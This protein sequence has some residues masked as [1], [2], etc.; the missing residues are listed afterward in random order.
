M[1]AAEFSAD[2]KFLYNTR[3][4]VTAAALAESLAAIDALAAKAPAVLKTI[5]P[6]IG[7]IDAQL[8]VTHI[9]IGSYDEHFLFRLVFGKGKVAERKLE[10]LRKKLKLDKMNPTQLAAL[11]LSG[12]IIYGV[13]QFSQS[14]KSASIH[15]ENSFNSIGG[16]LNMSGEEIAA[17]LD[18][19]IRNKEDLRRQTVKLIRP[20]GLSET[21]E[22][23]IAG[24]DIQLTLPPKALDVVPVSYSKAEPNEPEEL[25]VKVPAVIRALDLDRPGQGW[26]GILPEISERRLPVELAEGVNPLSITPGKITYLDVNLIHSVDHHGNKSPKRIVVER[27]YDAKD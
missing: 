25:L 6:R 10:A 17:I 8:L 2:Y 12:V 21:G 4:P 11:L 18:S 13:W 20:A 3:E 24:E 15:I 14:D 1:S 27:V 19:A 7:R 5:V 9:A 22:L 23:T 16:K 26:A